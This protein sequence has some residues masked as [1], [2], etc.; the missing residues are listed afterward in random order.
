MLAHRVATV[1]ADQVDLDET[2][3]RIVPVGP[4]PHRDLTLEQRARL[5][6]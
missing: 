1:M 2:R 5:G 3:D 4:R 6:T